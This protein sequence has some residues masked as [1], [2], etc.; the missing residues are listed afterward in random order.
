MPGRSGR[1]G[2]SIGLALTPL[3]DIVFLL[4]VFF[5]L[6]A[7][8]V[9]ERALDVQLPEAR[10]GEPQKPQEWLTVTLRKDGRLFVG[11]KAVSRRRLEETLAERLAENPARRIRVRGDT[12]AD[13]G[14]LVGIMD[15]ARGV[16]AG[17]VDLVTHGTE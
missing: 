1:R 3:V 9:E 16:G 12:Q 8:F 17:A 10:T 11:E 6:T 7:H 14:A 13:L 2:G 5:M 4:L 15:A